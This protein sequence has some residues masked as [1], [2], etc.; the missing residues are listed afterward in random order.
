MD[1]CLLERYNGYIYNRFNDLKRACSELNN[2]NMSKIFE[3][4]CCIMLSNIYDDT[5][6]EYSDIP[7]DFKEV[8][9]MSR[10][11][12]GIDCCNL[13]DT[14][15][16]CKLRKKQL[17]WKE[18]GTFFGSQNIY[19]AELDETIVRWKKLIITR[20]NDCNLSSILQ[21]KSNLFIDKTFD[22]EEFIDYCANLNPPTSPQHT[23]QKYSRDYQ[24]ECINLIKQ[25]DKNVIISLPTGTGK[26]F[27]I[28]R[29]LQVKKKYFILVPRIIL[30]EQM[31]NEITNYNKEFESTIQMIGDS[32]KYFDT[33][34]DIT[35]CVYNS[36]KI[37]SEYAHLC[38]KIYVD[39]A[40]HV[41]KP[42]IY[43]DFESNDT[44]L[45][46]TDDIIKLQTYN[47]NVYTSA[48]IDEK[49]GFDYYKKDV[50]TMINAGYICDYVINIPVWETDQTSRI[51][52]EHLINQYR[53]LIVYCK[54]QK[55]GRC[56]NDQF[57]S[58]QMGSSEYI[59]CDT[60]KH[61]RK[62]IL[63]KF[64]RGELQF[65]VN[66]NILV[67][68]FD[69]PITAG[70]CLWHL[71][72]SQTKL[73]Q[74]IGRALRNHP[75]K[76]YADIV[77]PFS[78]EDDGLGIG[79][80]MRVLAN[81]DKRIQQSVVSKVLG[82]YISVTKQSEDEDS[83]SEDED[84]ESEPN[85]LR[86][87][88]IYDSTFAMKNE[89]EI[90]TIH[91]NKLIEFINKYKKPPNK[92]NTN[93][94]IAQLGSWNST[95][96]GNYKSN[97]YC[98]NNQE[99]RKLWEAFVEKYKEYELTY[100][101]KWLINLNELKGYI[102]ECNEKPNIYSTDIT[103]RRLGCWISTQ[104]RN[105]K[106]THGGP[107]QNK[108][109]RR[110]WTEFVDEYEEYMLSDNE[111]WL[112]NLDKLKEYIDENKKLPETKTVLGLWC[113]AQKGNYKRNKHC[114]KNEK[115]HTLWEEFVD[116]YNEYLLS[117]NEKWFIKLNQLKEYIDENKKLPV[118]RC[119]YE[120][121]PLGTWL[122][123][124]KSNYKSNKYCMNNQEI[125]KKWEVFVDEYEEYMLSDNEKWLINLDK[126][127]E[128]IDENK[129][130][131]E[132]KTVLGHWC[133]MQKGNYKSNKHCMKNEKNHTLWE[134]F[135]DE[136]KE[137]MLSNSEKWFIKLN[138]LKEY[139]DENK[140][141]PSQK[142]VH[143]TT[144]MLGQWL[145]QQKN[146]YKKNIQSMKNGEILKK[147]EV[148]VDEYSEHM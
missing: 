140:K 62:N 61:H 142:S 97:K 45:T 122:S 69:A 28:A 53:S 98:M 19:N 22:R 59:D 114:M 16:Q 108:Y 123:Q 118:K 148:L 68:G 79:T 131:P 31:K 116:E 44:D 134:E 9:L 103:E 60:P 50:R 109:I 64:K 2:Y 14:I 119:K 89:V 29:S 27:I 25:S 130:L 11:D 54:S 17:C 33:N 52:C 46:Y 143:N 139:I 66:I 3:W 121:F 136:Y 127:K 145:S 71:P 37:I 115:N 21:L 72:A 99:I 20:N 58:L 4:Y 84:E 43:E 120:Q 144:R 48:T 76:K 101:E 51:V 78:N 34:K 42:A 83:K 91:L 111:K 107:M 146:N 92:N 110:L 5:F 70:V 41:H 100:D 126:L 104:K 137:Y 77:L 36:I 86:Y 47:N 133:S 105:Y 23:E 93:V 18:C 30:M 8:N 112:I 67:E 63:D 10:T 102:H 73:I 94:Y 125:L 40:H 87:N 85:Y 57:N 128:C 88:M 90:W 74:I 56:V 32:N 6:Y 39:E 113:S 13:V 12:T 135:V 75:Q 15:V 49:D 95:Q 35:I 55:E 80:F 132:T 117:D 26:N 24:I 141:L 138:K 65:L 124:Q 7:P 129:K 106:K 147:W 96:R 82:G 81:N 1:T 38:T